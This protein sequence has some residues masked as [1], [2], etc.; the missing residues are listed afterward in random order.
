MC[1]GGWKLVK[2]EMKNK[3][4]RFVCVHLCMCVWH[5]LMLKG[6]AEAFTASLM[7]GIGFQGPVS[8]LPQGQQ[9]LCPIHT[10]PE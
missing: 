3:D 8:T 4:E 10:L 7:Q 5:R 9:P 6:D 1:I 2:K